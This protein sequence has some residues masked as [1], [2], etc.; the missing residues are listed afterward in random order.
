[1]SKAPKQKA[2]ALEKENARIGVGWKTISDELFRPVQAK[3]I[4]R[5]QHPEGE[6]DRA[7]ANASNS[8][9]TSFGD[10]RD[11]V[12]AS[13]FGAGAAPGSGRFLAALGGTE[14]DKGFAKGLGLADTRQAAINQNEANKS[15]IVQQGLGNAAEGVAGIG[16]AATQSADQ[17][18]LDSRNAAANRGA[19]G[20]IAGAGLAYGANAGLNALDNPTPAFS[21]TGVHEAYNTTPA[22]QTTPLGLDWERG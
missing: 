8:Y 11:K 1:M 4:D 14:M 17:A 21:P 22:I 3:M 20:T 7:L 10:A 18:I 2:T 19:L 13:Q 6:I 16:R 12:V 5:V 9:E 15:A